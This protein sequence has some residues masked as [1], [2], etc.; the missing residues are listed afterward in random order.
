MARVRTDAA[1]ELV[2]NP[3]SAAGGGASPTATIEQLFRNGRRI[4]VSTTLIGQLH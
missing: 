2:G 1:R 4:G 3:R